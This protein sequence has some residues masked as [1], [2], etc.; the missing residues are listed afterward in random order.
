MLRFLEEKKY[1]PLGQSNTIHSDVRIIVASNVNLSK[2]VE[3]GKFR[4]DLFYRISVV[5]L[6]LT[7]LLN[8]KEDIPILANHFID[9]YSKLYGKNISGLRPDAILSLINHSWPGNIRQLENIIQEAIVLCPDEWIENHH[10]NFYKLGL[11]KFKA[12]TFR[13]AKNEAI[14]NFEQNYLISV[15]NTFNGNVS[16]AASF[17]NK[18]RREF[19]RLINKYKIKLD[20]YREL[21]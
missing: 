12:S 13:D 21:I 19:Y 1:K 11:N 3:A 14:K 2:M 4:S 17:A 5:N 15:L 9:K 20:Q 7:S 18:D 16:K 6:F 10:I 8:R